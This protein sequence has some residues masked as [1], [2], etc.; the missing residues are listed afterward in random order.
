M[1][2]RFYYEVLNCHLCPCNKRQKYTLYY[3]NYKGK[4]E[5]ILENE[6]NLKKLK[7]ETSQL[8]KRV[9]GMKSGKV[10]AS[11]SRQSSIFGPISENLGLGNE[12]V[13]S[14]QIVSCTH[15]YFLHFTSRGEAG[16]VW[17]ADIF[18]LTAYIIRNILLFTE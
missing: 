7:E 18:Y 13:H 15:V 6:N 16:F 5:G 4:K 8:R 17:S 9:A 3:R 2:K 1:K 14:T 12:F 11:K 10:R